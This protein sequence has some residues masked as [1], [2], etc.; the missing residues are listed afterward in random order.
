[1]TI[2]AIV[3]PIPFSIET[4]ALSSGIPSARA[5]AS[6]TITNDKNEL[7]FSPRIKIRSRQIPRTTIMSDI[8][9]WL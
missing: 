4:T 2:K 9:N 8:D 6:E 7:N 5:T 1:M 3:L